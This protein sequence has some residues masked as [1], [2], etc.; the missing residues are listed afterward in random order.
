MKLTKAIPFCIAWLAALPIS[1]VMSEIAPD[2]LRQKITVF[3]HSTDFDDKKQAEQFENLMKESLRNFPLFLEIL[4]NSDDD[5]VLYVTLTVASTASGTHRKDITDIAVQ[6]LTNRD[7]KSFPLT[8]QTALQTLGTLGTSEHISLVKH[9]ES[10][11]NTLVR[12]AAK[13][14]VNELENRE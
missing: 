3:A 9:F 2:D 10:D 11:P 13:T 12:S 7:S 14:A 5:R 4:R 6:L 8:A 1:Q